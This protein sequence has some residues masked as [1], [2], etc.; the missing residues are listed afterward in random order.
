[1]LN[2]L[3]HANACKPRPSSSIS[4]LRPHFASRWPSPGALLMAEIG[5]ACDGCGRRDGRAHRRRAASWR[6]RDAGP[7][8]AGLSAPARPDCYARHVH[9]TAIPPAASRILAIVWAPGQFSPPHAHDTWCAY[10][11]V[12]KCAGR[13][14]LSLRRRG[15]GRRIAC[16]RRSAFRA[17]VAMPGPGL[18]KSTGSVMPAAMPAISIHVYGV[19]ARACRHAREPAGG[20]RANAKGS[21]S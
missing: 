17:M 13:D 7:A 14:A 11:V 1:M 10:A 8:D 2:S 12:R 20:R 15:A 5:A 9:R 16:A 4:R 21:R 6:P 3:E 19:E 18:T